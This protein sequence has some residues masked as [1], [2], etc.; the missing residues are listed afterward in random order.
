M[1]KLGS[2]AVMQGDGNFVE[3]NSSNA[4]L[5]NTGTGGRCPCPNPHYLRIFDDG[6]LAI[7]YGVVPQID[8]GVIWSIGPDPAPIGTAVG[9]SEPIY[10]GPRPA[11]LPQPS[12]PLY[13][14]Y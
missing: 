8:V 5:W 4:P 6:N 14:D 11:T 12:M 10:P 3:Y 2:F 9:V 1:A 7:I 13:Y